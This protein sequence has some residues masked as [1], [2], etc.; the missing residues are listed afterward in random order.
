MYDDK[1]LIILLAL[2]S[3]F[4]FNDLRLW[5]E[6]IY[7]HFIFQYLSRWV[8]KVVL[9]LLEQ[10]TWKWRVVKV[11]YS[12]PIFM[13][14]PVTYHYI[15]LLTLLT[16]VNHFLLNYCNQFINNWLWYYRDIILFTLVA[17]SLITLLTL[18]SFDYNTIAK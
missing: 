7:F 6:K 12:G 11:G 15:I 9:K 13:A 16:L 18:S 1:P 5:R 2:T 8:Y 17:H 10:K 3:A 4:C 14:H